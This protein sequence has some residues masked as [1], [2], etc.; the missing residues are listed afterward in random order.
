MAHEVNLPAN[1]RFDP[2][3][4][5]PSSL[6]VPERSF[7]QIVAQTNVFPKVDIPFKPMASMDAGEQALFFSPKRLN[8]RAALS[9]TPLLLDVHM[10]GRASQRSN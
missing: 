4:P 10:E 9:Y 8:P 7:A 2:D 3:P 6:V 5:N 1:S